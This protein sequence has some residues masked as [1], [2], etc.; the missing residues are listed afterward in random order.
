VNQELTQRVKHQARQMRADLVGVASADRF[1]AMP[2]EISPLSIFPECQS[3]LVLG[4][5][6]LRGSIRGIE[7]GTSFSNTYGHFG[8]QW[9][10]DTF[11]AQTTYDVTCFIEELGFEAVPL[12]G[13]RPEGMPKG[14]PVAEGKPAPNVIVDLDFAAHAAGLGE[15]GLGGF[16]LTPQ[17]GTRQRL[18]MI[19][20]DAPLAADAVRD[21]QIC[22]DCGACAEACP[23]GAI[24]RETSR[25]VG[26]S[27][28]DMK[29]ATIDY[30]I[31]SRCPNGAMNPPG[32]GTRPDRIAAACGRA[33]LVKLEQARKLDNQFVQPF[34]KR[35]PW[36]LDSLNRPADASKTPGAADIGCDRNADT[37]GQAGGK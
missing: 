28:H 34:R 20:T 11:L 9:L 36:A 27:G 1:A 13:Y 33:C 22:S 24:D 8:C 23:L 3:V 31:C 30:G 19:L 17:Y 6:V 4:R 16:F 2:A 14:R 10:E 12:F 18:A 5:R 21:K 26:V 32:R 35:R 25:R 7:E 15:V 29:V 37:I